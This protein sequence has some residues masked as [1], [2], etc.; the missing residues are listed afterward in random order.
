[1]VVRGRQPTPLESEVVRSLL[2][3]SGR[4]G[5][6]RDEF[7]PS[8]GQVRRTYSYRLCPVRSQLSFVGRLAADRCFRVLPPVLSV[9]PRDYVSAEDSRG[10][11]ELDLWREAFDSLVIE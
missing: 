1:M 2:W 8:I 10:L 6:K 9:I 5:R 11:D 3:V 7:D 4:E